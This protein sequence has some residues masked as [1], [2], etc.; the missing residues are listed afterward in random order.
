MGAAFFFAAYG[1]PVLPLHTPCRGGC[2]CGS[3]DCE[4]AGK[5]PRL[6]RGLTDASTDP[7]TVAGWWRRWPTANLGLRT[8]VVMDVADV[9]TDAGRRAL[10]RVLGGRLP[11]GPV[12]RTGSGGWHLWF[13]PTGLGN[14]V[15]VLPGVD[16]RGAGGY[17]VAPPSRHASGTAYT[18]LRRPFETPLPVCPP[19][20]RELI[21]G[22]PPEPVRPV[23]H[24]DQYAAAVLAAA[25]ERVAAAPVGTRNDTL[26]RAAW[27]LGRLVGAAMLDEPTVVRALS[28]AARRSG[29][30]W[31]E[32]M[33][34]IRSGLRA[35]LM[36]T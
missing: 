7:A 9:D 35:G 32:T 34:T 17:V 28:A 8:G 18:W 19:R 31:T 4:R 36:R 30:S 11:D 10:I 5:H 33:R 29:L 6:R 22:P 26:N 13:A 16:W 12:A 1:I 24:P 25:A 21:A 27:S 20:L 2:S 14:R 23:A 15:G 3:A